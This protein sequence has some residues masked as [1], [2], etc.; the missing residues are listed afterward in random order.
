M[1]P[2]EPQTD[3]W[4]G[5]AHFSTG[6][7]T[8]VAPKLASGLISIQQVKFDGNII[9]LSRALSLALWGESHAHP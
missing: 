4:A 2:T 1:I 3:F 5:R 6:G 9:H 8:E 7:S